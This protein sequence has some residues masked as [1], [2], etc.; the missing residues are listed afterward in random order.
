[1]G[2]SASLL[3]V[4]KRKIPNPA[5]TRTPDHPARSCYLFILRWCIQKFPD[6][7]PGARTANGTALCHYVQSYRYFMSQYSEFCH[8]NS[9]CCFS[10]SVY[11]C[12]RLF[13]YRLSPETFGYSLVRPIKVKVKLS[14]CLTKH[15]AM[16]AY[17]EWRYSSTHS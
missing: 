15:Q 14:V 2:P 6:W 12:K 5:I 9:L 10:T 13:C 16:K 8:H 17:W 3:A 11:C 7:S 1:V 4:V